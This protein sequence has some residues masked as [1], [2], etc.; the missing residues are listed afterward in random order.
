MK[1]TK[2]TQITIKPDEIKILA[3]EGEKFI[4][5]P[6]AEEQLIKLLELQELINKTV[7]DVKNKIAEAGKSINPNFRGVIGDRVKCIYR[8][9]GAKYSY[10]WKKRTD[11]MPFLKEKVVYTVDS[12]RVD[13][14][15]KEV[16]EMP[17]G[18]SLSDRNNT[19]SISLKDEESERQ[20]IE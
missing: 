8:A 5:K 6:Q 20:L 4:F 15:L 19:L 17:D 3:Q 2:N 16:G 11:C 7:E 12:D 14:Y 1:S 18:I 13:K 10:D 9:Y